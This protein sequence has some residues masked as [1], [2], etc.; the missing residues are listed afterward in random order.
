MSGPSTPSEHDLLGLLPASQLVPSTTSPVRTAKLLAAAIVGFLF[1]AALAPWRQNVAGDG[2]VLALTPDDRPQAIEATISGRIARWAV[3]E[4]QIVE[5]GDVLVELRDNDP[6]RLA[7]ME[8]ERAAQRARLEAYQAQVLAY[9]ERVDALRES[10]SAQIA[11]AQ[12]EVRVAQD[13]LASQEEMLIAAEANVATNDTQQTRVRTLAGEGLAS[14]RD[15]ELAQLSATSAS[16]SLRSSQARLRAAAAA[17]RVKRASLE[18]VRASTEADLR[19]ADAALRSA[20]T[21][22]SSVQAT[23]A[24]LDSRVAQQSAQEIRAVSSFRRFLRPVPLRIHP[25]S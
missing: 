12:A 21:Q 19:S 22:V 15:R 10:Q 1:F 4:G 5:E 14:Q 20:E 3:I 18:R 8:E 16:A 13:S 7:R 6:D 2:R 9:R 17:L 25:V 23:L 24:Q 11:A